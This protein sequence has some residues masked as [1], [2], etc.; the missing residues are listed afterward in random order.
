M[1]MRGIDLKK[2]GVPLE[3]RKWILRWVEKYKQG[4]EPYHISKIRSE[5][6]TNRELKKLIPAKVTKE[7]VNP[8]L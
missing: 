2:A 3:Q 8:Y 5:S 6:R 4:I 1:L 7:P